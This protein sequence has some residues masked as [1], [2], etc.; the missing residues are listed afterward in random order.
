[1]NKDTL[2]KVLDIGIALSKEKD[3]D[4]LMEQ[5]LNAAM[6]I[7]RCDGGT[8]YIRNGNML[9]FKIM[10]TKS[11]GI[12]QGGSGGEITMPPVPL[13]RENVCACGVLYHNL[14]N[15]PSVY[16]SEAYDFSGPKKYDAIT[17][18]QTKTMMVVPMEDDKGEV[19]GVIQLINALDEE[20]NVIAFKEEYEQIILSMA[21]QAAICLMNRKYAQQI[22]K[23]LDSF[24]QVMTTAI[25]ERTPCTANHTRN[26][27]VYAEQFIDW[28]NRQDLGWT[29]DEKEKYVFLMS[30]RLHDIGKL[31]TP[32]EIM[33][34]KDRL[35]D[36]YPKIMDRL[37]KISLLTKIA[38]LEGKIG[39]AEEA[40]CQKRVCEAKELIDRVNTAGF[41][42]EELENQVYK[43]ASF[44]YEE[45]PG[46]ICPWITKE[47]LEQLLIRKGTLTDKERKI[48]QDHVEMTRRMLEQMEFGED[49]KDVV[50][51]ASQH[52][53][54]LNG[55]GYPRGIRADET[56]REV[57]LLVIIDV[58]EALTARDRP[59]KN[60][61]PEEK[62]LGILYRMAENGEID[63]EILRWFEASQAWTE[64]GKG[65][66]G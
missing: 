24:V 55:S 46:M 27:A 15:I 61:M 45:E 41:L 54:R 5:I 48:M 57:R 12:H 37:E 49:Y 23:M 44:T 21:S 42:T 47:E 17:G 16:I 9:E 8:L 22:Q 63:M 58:F 43:L 30:V 50:T 6:D 32:L 33:D 51:F 10:I 56:S 62:A 66:E 59:Y 34:K 28:L 31:I 7:T 39:E 2:Q 38:R 25:D 13:S 3:I 14:I 26:M 35:S 40:D 60:P 29:F 4:C 11:R 18:Y 52:H 1:M 36:N 20:G 19:I 65:T 64:R 53:E